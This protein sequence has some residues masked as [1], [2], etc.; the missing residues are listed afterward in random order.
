MIKIGI[1]NKLFF[2]PDKLNNILDIDLSKIS[3]ED[4]INHDNL[5]IYYIKYN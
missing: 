1:E 2:H 3:V 4:I 5:G